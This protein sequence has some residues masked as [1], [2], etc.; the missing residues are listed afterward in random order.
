[1]IRI[2]LSEYNALP[3]DSRGI[4]TTERDDLPNWAEIRDK[5]MGRRT[6]IHYDNGAT[7]LLVEGL[8]FEIVE[9]DFYTRKFCCGNSYVSRQELEGFPCPFC[10]KETTDA[11]MQ[12]IV[13]EADAA[14]R[15]C[16]RIP[17]DQP[18][19]FKN[20]EQDDT[21]WTE[22][23]K[24]A[25]RQGIPYY[26]DIIEPVYHGSPNP[27]VQFTT[28][29]DRVIYFTDSRTVAEEFARAEGHGGLQPGETPTLIHARITL[30]RLYVARSED[31]WLKEADDA[32]IDKRK[33]VAEGYDGICYRNEHDVT[34]YAVFDS[35]NC[36]ILKREPLADGADTMIGQI[37]TL[38]RAI[39]KDHLSLENVEQP[40]SALWW[41]NKGQPNE[42]M[43]LAVGM[44]NKG[45][46]Y[47]TLDDGC[48]GD[49]QIWESC[50]QLSDND[51]EPVLE[52]MREH[53][54]KPTEMSFQELAERAF[55][56]PAGESISFFCKESCDDYAWGITKTRQL[57][58][59]L[60]IVGIYGGGM[61]FMYDLTSDPDAEELGMFIR[62]ILLA[63]TP[64]NIW[65]K[66]TKA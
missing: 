51:L 9:G 58:T 39:S 42:T 38:L 29:G 53:M 32:V 11:Q 49:V 44:D 36:E 46:L 25:V 50:G 1:M 18:I 55:A 57:D 3:K 4:W 2:T 24:A 34:Y 27:N 60:V 19:D 64:D 7:V 20:E 45:D 37:K 56:L 66:N 15:A 28:D 13:D 54:T 8:S 63:F 26:E 22:L 31:E 40:S 61:T 14:T 52:N 12:R 62:N 10:T 33:W 6:M 30:Q 16:W 47:L 41:D 21:W 17:A 35:S 23:E 5:H 48:G 43:V 65:I 59:D